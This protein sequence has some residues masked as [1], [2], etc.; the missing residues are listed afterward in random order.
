MAEPKFI[1]HEIY[2][3]LHGRVLLAY[4][5]N[6]KEHRYCMFGC[7]YPHMHFIIYN[8]FSKA[9]YLV[10]GACAKYILLGKGFEDDLHFI[11]EARILDNLAIADDALIHT[12]DYERFLE[13]WCGDWCEKKHKV[14]E[15]NEGV[16]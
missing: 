5:L 6:S 10:C 7:A 15:E 16:R 11:L 14:E 9:Y 2:N 4:K 13:K 1:P 8:E 3:I 12:D